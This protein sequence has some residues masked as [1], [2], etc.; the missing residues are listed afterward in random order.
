VIKST[1]PV[2]EKE[3]HMKKL[4]TIILAT[5]ML[6]SLVALAACNTESGTTTDTQTNS[7]GN[8][9]TGTEGGGQ[10]NTG[11]DTEPGGE[12]ID[13]ANTLPHEY[14]P[15]KLAAGMEVLVA[16]ST[17]SF[18]N[19]TAKLL[20]DSYREAFTSDGLT[21]MSSASGNDTATQIG[22][23]ENYV[24]MGCAAII[25]A[26]GDAAGLEDCLLQAEAAGTYTIYFGGKPDYVIAATDNMD[27]YAMGGAVAETAIAWLDIQYPDAPAGSIKT[28]VYGFYLV[29][30]C[31]FISDGMKD[32]I[33]TDPR[34]DLIFFDENCQGLDDGYTK[35][36]QAYTVD[37]DV[38]LFLFYDPFAAVG[39]NNFV[40]SLPGVDLAEYAVFATNYS[41]EIEDLIQAS[42]NNESCLRGTVMGSEDVAEGTIICLRKLLFEK[43]EPPFDYVE[44]IFSRNSFDYEY[45]YHPYN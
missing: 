31:G 38:K 12:E 34:V 45:I 18:D 13:L 41:Q 14:V 39:A 5:L 17:T 30:E 42:Q 32:I 35:A 11:G 20:D 16:Y 8:T 33:S 22:Q 26:T 4:L 40:E 44:S 15:E 9:Q 3:E 21:Y 1:K 2:S 6:L 10:T 36:E 29:T 7:G 37:S 23:I 43:V 27:L 28:A 19:S 25:V 24:T